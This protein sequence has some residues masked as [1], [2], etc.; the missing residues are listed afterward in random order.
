MVRIFDFMARILNR[1]E[2]GQCATFF[3]VSGYTTK[4][5]IH[6]KKVP[7]SL[8]NRIRLIYGI[9]MAKKKKKAIVVYNPDDLTVQTINGLEVEV[10]KGELGYLP[11]KIMEDGR[12]TYTPV[13]FEAVMRD[14]V[15]G[16]PID[17]ACTVSGTHSRFIYKWMDCDSSGLL[18]RYHQRVSDQIARRYATEAIAEAERSD[19]DRIEQPNGNIIPDNAAVQRSKLRIMSRQWAAE[20]L[21]RRFSPH[22]RQEQVDADGNTTPAI[23]MVS[24]PTQPIKGQIIDQDA[25]KVDDLNDPDGVRD[26]QDV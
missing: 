17:D 21:S 9:S 11:V 7:D 14:W 13:L 8:T 20:R 24:P 12:T 6:N 26:T 15:E 3:T 19:R 25:E 5:K 16:K 18:S 1:S 22:T 10:Y 2:S 23:V 4:I